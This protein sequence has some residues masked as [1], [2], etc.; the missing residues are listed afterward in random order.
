VLVGPGACITAVVVDLLPVSDAEDVIC[1]ALD[2][3]AIEE[4]GPVALEVAVDIATTAVEVVLLNS[5]VES[6]HSKVGTPLAS[7]VIPVP[8]R[9][10]GL[11][12]QRGVTMQPVKPDTVV[13][14]Q[15]A[16]TD[17]VEVLNG[18]GGRTDTMSWLVVV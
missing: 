2:V 18:R 10:N 3:V 4:D 1:M 9:V 11:T 6:V 8:V 17:E 7:K 16:V 14:W 5:E 13:L 15:T 12:E